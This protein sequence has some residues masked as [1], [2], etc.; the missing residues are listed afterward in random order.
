MTLGD[1]VAVLRDGLLQQVGTPQELFRS[2]ANVFVASF[3]GSPAMNLAHA[4]VDGPVVHFAGVRIPW[5]DVPGLE[6][7]HRFDGDEVV[8]GIRPSDLEDADQAPTQWPVLVARVD[9]T[10]DLGSEIHAIFTVDASSVAAEIT[11]E[12]EEAGS[13]ITADLPLLTGGGAVFRA[14]MHPRTGVQPGSSVR[15]SLDPGR[16]H[17]FDPTSGARIGHVRVSN[18]EGESSPPADQL[19]RGRGAGATA[20]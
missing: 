7:L 17:F 15:L 19:D 5:G 6:A 8:V 11:T 20:R 1:R 2:P 18:A 16:M 10:E 12:G 9:V 13:P 14:S 3:I 4:R